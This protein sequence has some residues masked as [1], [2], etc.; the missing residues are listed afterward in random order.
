MTNSRLARFP[1]GLGALALVSGIGLGVQAQGVPVPSGRS[2]HDRPPQTSRTRD[3]ICLNGLWRFRPETHVPGPRR[4]FFEGFEDP[5]LAGWKRNE[6]ATGS[7][8]PG[9]DTQVVHGGK[10]ALRIA[11]HLPAGANFYHFHRRIDLEPDTPYRLTAYV[12]TRLDSGQFRLEI[13]DVR[14]YKLFTTSTGTLGRAPQWRRVRLDFRTPKDTRAVNVYVRY[15]GRPPA[16]EGTVWLDDL[17]IDEV[18]EP[19]L[20]KFAPPENARWGRLKVPGN[21]AG[22]YFKAGPPPDKPA[23]GDYRRLRYAWYERALPIPGAWKGRR[24]L[25][26]LDKV[27]TDAVVW[28]NGRR[29]GRLGYMG[30]TVD[31]TQF[32]TPGVTARVDIFV[33]AREPANVL[34]GLGGKRILARRPWQRGLKS[35]GL[36]GDAWLESGPAA[37]PR[38]GSFLVIT[39][40]RKREIAVRAGIDATDGAPTGCELRIRVLDGDRVVKRF[41][42]SVPAG[43]RR[44]RATAS[45]SDAVLWDVG[46]PK[47]YH[48]VVGLYRNGRLLDESLPE[49]F[50]FR[51]FEIR[52][53][54]FYLNGSRINLRPASYTATI[55]AWAS[56]DCME[57][58]LDK[59]V[60]EG[61]NFVYTATVDSPGQAG[62]VR[63]FL[64]ACDEKGVLTAIT[65]AQINLC[66]DM[67]DQPDVRQAWE[68]A[69]RARVMRDWNHPSLVLWRMNMNLCGYNQDQNPLL[70]DS[71]MP[72]PP[73]SDKAKKAAAALASNAFVEA[74]D[75]TRKT[76]NHAGGDTGNI[77]TLNN[78]LCWPQPQD[79]REWLRVW[80]ERGRKPLMMVEFDL[81]YPGSF[82]MNDPTHWWSN[83]PLMA[84][85]GAILLGP[86]AYRLVEPDYLDFIDDYAWDRENKTW[87]S[88][89]G[90]YCFAFPR[91]I[92]EC[93]SEFYRI[94]VPAWRTWGIP[95]GMNSWENTGRRLRR[96]ES[97]PGRWRMRAYAPDLPLPADERSARQPGFHP[98]VFHYARGGGGEVRCNFDLDRPEEKEYFEPTLR[99]K[100]MR[101]VC[102]PVIAWIAGPGD[103]WTSVDHA[104]Y[105]GERVQ[106]DLVII[107]DSRRT[108]RFSVRWQART[109]RASLARGVSEATVSPGA[110]ARI[111]MAFTAPSVGDRTGVVFSA[112]VRWADGE[113]PVRPFAV[114]VFAKSAPVR[115]ELRDWAL[116]DPAGRTR[117]ALERIGVRVPSIDAGASLPPDLRVLVI[118]C[119]ALDRNERPAWFT[120]LPDRIADGLQVLVFEQSAA[121]LEDDFGLRAVTRGTSRL[122][123]CDAASPLVRG[124]RNEDLR[125][126]RGSSTLAPPAGKPVEGPLDS[127]RW[128]HVWRCTQRNVV[129]STVVEKPHRG[130]FRPIVHGEFDLRCMALW[131][132]FEGRGRL[133]FCQ[134]DVTDRLGRDPVADRVVRNLLATLNAPRPFRPGPA[135]LFAGDAARIEQDLAPLGLAGARS[136]AAV[137]PNLKPGAAR[138]VLV[139]GC[140]LWVRRNAAGI[141]AFLASGG[142]A[143]AVGLAPEDARELAKAAQ[144]F[145][146]LAIPGLTFLDVKA[147]IGPGPASTFAGVGPAELCWREPRTVVMPVPRA[148]AGGKAYP[149]YIVDQAPVG[150]G[151]IVWVPVLPSDFDPGRRP[152]LIFTKVNTQRLLALVLTNLG[153]GSTVTWSDGFLKPPSDSADRPPPAHALSPNRFYTDARTPRD[154]PYAYMRW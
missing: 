26:R 94:V 108:A 66:W 122:W 3:R 137:L 141:R 60:A 154:D 127:Q 57:R 89:Y 19:D 77:Y 69:V 133:I 4:V 62:W 46:S 121:V 113:I 70:L 68:R 120:E 128:K 153:V 102:R 8:T 64:E 109:G 138:L 82:S 15:Y 11:F 92:D 14:G 145:Q 76:Y 150:K 149:R 96:I 48:L 98:D 87:R 72:L 110:N 90:Y 80:A 42:A 32:V 13:Q 63:H 117:A 136:A 38:L 18:R 1:T 27:A 78:Y 36:V 143:V 119:L 144:T 79:L 81:P 30:G 22:P 103:D 16:L 21:W 123:L 2:H 61:H 152:D 85:Y 58:W 146:V 114:Q 47:L 17:A 44:A 39:S 50:G 93:S 134:L 84:E 75:P 10:R 101:E 20:A 132:A 139:R 105:A 112:V 9:S 125:N 111:S 43:A 7:W 33:A 118:G 135:V 41:A 55:L 71:S 34:A 56:R 31:L 106:K 91:I 100:V 29:A 67:L 59:T 6:L 53:K 74:L 24:V 116:Y 45:W 88:A 65:P 104:F 95:G 73:D 126:W 35:R 99:G 51:E 115:A 97:T 147:G 23:G 129:A 52:G 131:E 140:S 107:N 40:V 86:R 124:L 54:F 28:C 12:R 142:S 49:R 25:L 130:A 5:A 151:W 148:A 37:P 83:E